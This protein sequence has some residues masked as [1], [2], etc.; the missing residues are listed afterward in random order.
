MNEGEE[1]NSS[2]CFFK[3]KGV[4][5]PIV[6]LAIDSKF[7]RVIGLGDL[8]RIQ[9]VQV[10]LNIPPSEVGVEHETDVVLQ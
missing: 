1:V 3:A 5:L 9:C 10:S 6:H 7:D 8:A 2:P 4:L